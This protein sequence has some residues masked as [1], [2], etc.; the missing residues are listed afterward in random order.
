MTLGWNNREARGLRSSPPLLVESVRPR[1]RNR[2]SPHEASSHPVVP[3]TL[4]SPIDGP[5]TDDLFP[6][7]GQR[8][9]DALLVVANRV[10][11]DKSLYSETASQTDVVCTRLEAELDEWKRRATSAEERLELLQ[12]R[13]DEETA[14]LRARLAAAADEAAVAR[15]A[16]QQ[17]PPRVALLE[18]DVARA[19]ARA[20][21]SLIHI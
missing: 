13:L 14:E 3:T 1:G 7:R 5:D 21:L 18:E 9:V 10:L 8:I 15:D 16:A 12:T 17:F 2:R 20:D 19:Q 4:H 6:L 11:M